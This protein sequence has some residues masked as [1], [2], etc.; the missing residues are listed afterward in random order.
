MNTPKPTLT[1]SELYLQVERHRHR[2]SAPF[3]MA[4]GFQRLANWMLQP[5]GD[6]DETALTAAVVDQLKSL[7]AAAQKHRSPNE[8]R[9][10]GSALNEMAQWSTERSGRQL[11]TVRSYLTFLDVQ[12]RE[13]QEDTEILLE[14]LDRILHGIS[15]LDVGTKPAGD[16]S[17]LIAPI[18]RKL[19]EFD[20]QRRNNAAL[21]QADKHKQEGC[22]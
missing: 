1:M 16:Y 12:W 5:V 7:W 22:A 15:T 4:E 9:L 8:V 13:D 21:C 14:Q 17:A 18:E 20:I 19:T 2:N 10:I 6:T 3:D 11:A